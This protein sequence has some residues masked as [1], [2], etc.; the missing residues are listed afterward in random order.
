MSTE[1]DRIK[2]DARTDDVE[3]ALSA[4][5]IASQQASTSITR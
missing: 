3:H 2:T 4:N 1:N 5:A